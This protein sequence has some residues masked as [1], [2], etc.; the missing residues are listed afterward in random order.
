GR[1]PQAHSSYKID[2][3]EENGRN[4]IWHG[5]RVEPGRK[6][7]IEAANDRPVIKAL[8]KGYGRHRTQ[9]YD[10]PARPLLALILPVIDMHR[11]KRMAFVGAIHG[12]CSSAWEFSSRA[13]GAKYASTS[14]ALTASSVSGCQRG[15]WSL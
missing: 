15:F 9:E 7:R 10:Q 14:A 12:A 13:S 4:L 3:C 5:I 1:Q 6:R 2:D 11:L 8:A